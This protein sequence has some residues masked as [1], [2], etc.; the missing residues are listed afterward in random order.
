MGVLGVLGFFDGND[1]MSSS[2]AK[3]KESAGEVRRCR[4]GELPLREK[5]DDGLDHELRLTVAR[6]DRDKPL[7]RCP[8]TMESL[9]LLSPSGRPTRPSHEPMSLPEQL[10]TV[11]ITNSAS[12]KRKGLQ[13]ISLHVLS[14]PTP[15]N[16][17]THFRFL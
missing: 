16:E 7:T 4:G 1:S 11:P 12:S 2:E 14:E 17:L 10:C 5:S 6:F 8:N 9:S 3:M 13:P 15:N